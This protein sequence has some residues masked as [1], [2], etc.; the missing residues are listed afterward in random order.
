M[1]R[2]AVEARQP[3]PDDSSNVPSAP[4]NDDD[5]NESNPPNQE[6]DFA[7]NGLD[8]FDA[9]IR[10]DMIAMYV[11]VLRFKEGAT[12]ALYNNQ[13]ITDTNGLRELDDPTIKELCRQIGKEG[14]PVSMISQN[15]LKLLVFWAKHMQHTS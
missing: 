15:H 4:N 9:I 3:D 10:R 11:R 7:P 14:H 5:D 12:T 2:K 8:N 1:A 13:Q 6:G